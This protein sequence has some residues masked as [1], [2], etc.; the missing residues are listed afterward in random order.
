MPKWT[1]EQEAEY[2]L[3]Y[4]SQRSSLSKPAQLAYDQLQQERLERAQDESVTS[5]HQAAEQQYDQDLSCSG[6][7]AELTPNA[8]FCA[9][10]GKPIGQPYIQNNDGRSEAA[11]IRYSS[12]IYLGL[13]R[14]LSLPPQRCCASVFLPHKRTISTVS[15][16]IK[17]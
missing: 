4:G 2:A 16:K 13:T 15:V 10:C 11:F 9:S 7:G 1:P 5:S 3:S 12:G 14:L 8:R 6:C 17:N